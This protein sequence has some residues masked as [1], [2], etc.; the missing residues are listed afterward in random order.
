MKKYRS[1]K[2]CDSECIEIDQNNSDMTKPVILNIMDSS[3]VDLDT[4]GV[5]SSVPRLY[6]PDGAWSRVLH[7]TPHAVD[8]KLAPQLARHKIELYAHPVSGLSPLKALRTSLRMWRTIKSEKVNLVRGRLPY[9][10][11]LMG[12]IA[13]RLRGIP[14]VVSLGGDNRIVQEKNQ[15]YNYNSK[16]ISYLMEWLVLRLASSIIVPNRYTQKYVGTIIG[17]KRAEKKCARI[18]WLSDPIEKL[19]SQTKCKD[20]F[21]IQPDTRLVLIVG[22]LNQYKFTDI[23]FQMLTLMKETGELDKENLQ[24][25]FCGDGPLREEGEA[26]FSDSLSVKFL[27]WTPRDDVHWLMRKAEIV[28]IPMS[29][30]VLLEAASLGKPVITSNVEWHGEMVK[31][32]QTG[33]IVAPHDSSAWKRALG[34][35]LDDP[36][37]AEAM[38]ESLEAIFWA[39]YSPQ[40]SIDAEI[41]L[42]QRLIGQSNQ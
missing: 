36:K 14:F 41:E 18:P 40:H 34:Q 32:N 4:K 39:D 15:S 27:G 12:V 26:L 31:N 2:S 7:F 20:K 10:G 37:K 33:L 24:F 16:K 5:L 22:F 30:F 25:V 8:L 3:L 13:A 28:L 29:G 19:A 23:L 38:G 9:L 6:N 35:M 42:Y 21:N 17:E 11:S 1:W